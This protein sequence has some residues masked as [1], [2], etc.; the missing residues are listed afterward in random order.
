LFTTR[1]VSALDPAPFPRHLQ[2]SFYQQSST[3]ASRSTGISDKLIRKTKGRAGGFLK[4]FYK[5][6]LFMCNMGTDR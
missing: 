2:D 6:F 4:A 3:C 5:K 1:I